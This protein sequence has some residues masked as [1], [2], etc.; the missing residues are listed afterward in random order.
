MTFC[1]DFVSI[2][3]RLYVNCF[4]IFTSETAKQICLKFSRNDLWHVGWKE[5]SFWSGQTK[6]IETTHC[7]NGM[8][9][10]IQ[11]RL[12]NILTSHHGQMMIL[13]WSLALQ[14]DNGVILRFIIH[15]TEY[16]GFYRI[17]KQPQKGISH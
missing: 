2:V 13:S 6:N 12:M 3:R 15:I 4:K 14:C 17:S 10:I 7:P 9:A 11:S 8:C 5:S 16:S 1:H